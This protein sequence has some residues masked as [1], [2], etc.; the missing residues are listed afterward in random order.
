MSAIEEMAAAIRGIA[1]GTGPSVVGLGNG[2]RGG[3]GVVL[4]DGLVLTNAHNLRRDGV[5]VVF[6]D[7]RTVE[8]SVAGVDVEGDLAVI[9]VETGGVKPL[10]WGEPDT[11]AQGTPVFALSNPRGQGLRVSLGFISGVARSFRGPRGR[12]IGGSLEHTAPLLPGSSGG[13]VVDSDGRLL[14]INTNRL[15]E[16][17]YLAIPADPAL[18]QRV[19][20]LGRGE[21]PVRPRLGIAVAP[22]HVAR[23]MRRSVG[24]PE[25]DGLLVRGV[26]ED[27]PAASAGLQEGDLVVAVGGAPVGS[28]DDLQDALA[29][30]GLA[31]LELTVV[32]G[33]EERTVKVKPVE[34]ATN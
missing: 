13:P 32:R 23:R 28:V 25:R 31:E 24:L 21:A 27:G 10:T 2:W 7:G 5:S 3:S 8:G 20:A 11:A 16:G 15:G 4:D 19:E 22:G 26:E 18:R 33:T 17:F 34:D 29:A 30:S 12:R 1:E 14:G 6:G 9:R